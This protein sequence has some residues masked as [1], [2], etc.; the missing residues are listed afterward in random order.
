M[1][2]SATASARRQFR[3][4]ENLILSTYPVNV[5]QDE[6]AVD[7]DGNITPAGRGLGVSKECPAG[8]TEYTSAATTRTCRARRWRRRT[9]PASPR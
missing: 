3:T 2:G 7:A 5:L 4:N 8:V 9:P 1:A 6:G